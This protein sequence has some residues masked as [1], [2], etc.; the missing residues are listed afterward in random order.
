[1]LIGVPK[2]I[3]NHEYR[4]GLTPSGVRELV[5]NAHKV[6]VQTQAGLA[7]GFTDE[8]YIQAGASIAS[9]A[10]E[11]FERSDM[12]V[13]VKEPQPVECRMLRRDQLLFTYL[14]LAPDPEQTKLLLESDAIAIAYE[15]VTDE[16]G[17]LPLLAPMSEVAGRMAIQ[18]GAH[19]L[20]KAQGGRGVLL[21][22]VPGVAPAR[23]V[24]IG[25]GVVGLNAARMA[26]GAGAE[27]TILDKSLPR[28]KEID[29]VFGGR[30]K[31][32][33]SNSANIEDSLREA[34][35]VIGAVLIPGAAAPKLVTRPMLKIMKPGAVLVDVAIDQGGCFETSRPTTHQDPI[36]VVDG[37]VHY[38]VANMPGGVA[39]TSTQALTNATL[40]YTLELANKGWRQA[41]LD[42]AHLRN[43]LNV[44]R[45]RLT[46]QAVAQALGH[47]FIDPIE[48]IKAA[49]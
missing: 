2:E 32:L 29:M 37:I 3:K 21:G 24:V 14:H 1:M 33:V 27:V 44:C 30:I 25:G 20:E 10:E 5:A 38:C 48:A 49:S 7:I 15:T 17:G 36:Y 43:G 42:N 40:P 23:V 45:G 11:T 34:D 16:R 4:V 26:M 47:P 46:Y 39:R 22:G 9:S 31:T 13:K 35:L 12:I 19:A 18:A 28:L 8:Q 41:L 6:L